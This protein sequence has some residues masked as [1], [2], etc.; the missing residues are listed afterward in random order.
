MTKTL[1]YVILPDKSLIIEFYR[2]KFY[3][4]ELIDF[5]KRVGSDKKYNP[6]YDI[7]HD[8][9]ELEFLFKINEVSKY[10]EVIS[11]NHKYVGNRKSTMLTNTPNQVTTSLGFEILKK[12]LPIEVKVCSELETAL[13]F[14]G[15]PAKEWL[16]I[17]LELENLKKTT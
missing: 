8:F 10:V 12:N 7:I 14:I 3:V 5:K 1:D 9:R 16:S 15:Q 11:K 2:G 4:D 6:N 13:A 17:E